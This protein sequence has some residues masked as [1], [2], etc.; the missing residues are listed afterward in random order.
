[1]GVHLIFK[2]SG[3]TTQ[4]QRRYDAETAPRCR[5]DIM[6][7]LLLRCAPVGIVSRVYI[8]TLEPVREHVRGSGS[9]IGPISVLDDNP[10]IISNNDT[11]LNVFVDHS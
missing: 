1:M 4:L 7:T 6:M 2:P 3:H 9:L 10:M 5:F 8:Q 11:Y